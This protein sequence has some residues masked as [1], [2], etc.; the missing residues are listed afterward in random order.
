MSHRKKGNGHDLQ[1]PSRSTSREELEV[2]PV[3]GWLQALCGWEHV[4]ILCCA[5]KTI[6]HSRKAEAILLGS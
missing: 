4:I 5:A 2:I 1:K 3:S 6:G